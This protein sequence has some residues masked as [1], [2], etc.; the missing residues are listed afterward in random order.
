M[1]LTKMISFFP[2]SINS[3]K[4]GWKWIIEDDTYESF[5]TILDDLRKEPIDKYL[6]D[7]KKARDYIIS[8]NSDFGKNSIREKLIC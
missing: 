6:S 7:T 8:L 3:D 4:Q 5:E 2:S 1:N